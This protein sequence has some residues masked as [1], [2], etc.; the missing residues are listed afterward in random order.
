MREAICIHIG[1]GGVQIGNACWE[2]FCLEHG[3][4]PDGQMP[5]DKTIGGGDD[6]FNTFFSETGAGKHVPR[7]VMVDLEPTVVDEVR[8]GTYRQLFHPEQLISGK[9]DAAN[10]FARGH[11]TIGKEIVDLVLD[12]IRKLA[13]NCT[14]LQ[15]FCVY[16]ACGG[17]TGSG[18]GCLMLERLS[19]DYGKKSKISFTVWCC[20]QVATAVV[21]PYNT[22]LCVHS[23]LEHTDV[24]I[25][26][27]NEALYDICRRNL[28]IERPT[29]TN[30]NRLIAQIISSLT[31]SLRFDG[32]LNV[33]ITE[34]QTNLVPYPRIHFMLTSY[35]PVISAEKAYH[36]Q[37]S[38]AEITM[39]V[40]EP[41]SMMVKCDPRH[42]KYMAC[43]MMY[44]GD[45]VPKDVN[46]AVATIK[47]KRTI[48]F[49]DWCPTGF[50]CGINY[51]PPT[52]VPGGDLAKVMRACC[53]ISNSTAIAEVFSRIDH[54]FDLMYSKRA[55]VHHYVGEGMEEGEFSEA[56]ED[57][58]A[59]EKDYEEVGIETA[60]GEVLALVADFVGVRRRGLD[61]DHGVSYAGTALG[62]TVLAKQIGFLAGLEGLSAEADT[63]DQEREGKDDALYC[64]QIGNACWELFCLEHGIQPDGQMPSDKT[65]GGGDDAFNTF[66]S[67]TGAGKHVPR[68]VMVDL[69]PTVVDEVRT[70][71][72]RQLFHPE[73]LISGKEDAANNF[74][75][76]HYTIGKEIVDLVLDRIRKLADN[77]TGLQG[78][79]VYNACGG[80]TGSGLGCLMLERLSV[81]YGKKSK[82]SFT[83]WCCPQ[84]AT[85]V[86]E[87]YNTVLCVHSLL[88][89]TDVTIMYDNE[90]LYDICRRNLDIER[91]TYTN[92][93]RLIAQII[94][95]LTASLRFDGALNVDITEF[96]TNLVP[97]PRIHFM[98]T[99][100]AP[101]ISAEKAY[102]EQLSVAEITM[103]VFEPASMMVK[104][105]P[106]HGKYMACCMMYRGDVVPKDVNAAVATIKTKRT[107]QFVDW[108]PTGFKCG[109]N[110]QPPTVVPGGDLAKVMRACCMISNSTAIAEVFSR[111]D[112]KFDLMYSKRAF[113]HHYV[114]E[115][116]EEGEFSE[117][118][119]DLA[120]LEKDYEEV[121]I[122]TAEGEGEEEGYGAICIH[123][124]QGGVQIGN[125]CWELFCLEHGIQPD[126]QMPSDKTIGG[127]DDAFNTFFS[128]TG[129]GKHVPRCVMVDLEPTVVDEVR[130]G[131][132]RQLFHPEQLISGKE[133]AANNF[134]RGHYTIGKEIVDLVLDRIRKLADNC[135]GLQGFCVY[136]ACGGGTGS[137]LGCLMLE[138]LSVDY[139]K[140][141]KISFT[142]WCCPQVATAVVEPYNTVLCVH[143]LLE[144]T[145][146]TIMYDNEA[147]Y[148]ICRRNLDIERPT[149][150]NL[151]RLIAQIISSLTASL[152]FD[153]AL[154]V[155]ITE[156]QTNLVPYPRIHFMLTSYAPVISAEKAY[157]EQLSV[158]EITM[159]VFEP[160][161]MMVKCDPR[162]GK[163]MACCMMYRGDVVP[164]DVNAA[165]ATIKTKRT[166][167]FVDWCPTGFKCG[168]NYQ[169]PT[170]VPGGDLAKVMRACCMISNSTAIAEV[171]SRID[172]KFDLMYS[173]RAFVHHYVGEGMEEGEFSEARED[174][175]ALEKD[176]EEVGIETA[177]GEGEEEGYGDEF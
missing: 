69:E 163:Y 123:I 118:R 89:H 94:S 46:A 4:Q 61:S 142:V 51:Q 136:N 2:L 115:G 41:A 148:D 45:V 152:R 22:V 60:E 5:S 75:R 161:S 102:H 113:V 171:F 36:E 141:S 160:A 121:G 138:R 135:T 33:D 16:N 6:A 73:Q 62:D 83:V 49:V 34:F 91:P 71:T 172:H 105:D 149:Y 100:Y 116:M 101:V 55:F 108:C 104:C 7:C 85:A 84:V 126:G 15:G 129:A 93:N 159:S 35:A 164:K 39:S 98:L 24:T 27:D 14:G 167:Q 66:F 20:P 133:D 42:G 13:D 176:Y 59:L 140:K 134:A 63:A 10:N 147:L 177:E 1:Q 8:T 87:P 97:Y 128:E 120:A 175:A 145:D 156:F 70:G 48:Q 88:E 146:V 96:Q 25:M 158:A 86:V 92:L 125:A 31:A 107:I 32:A 65:I 21:E 112:H 58:A 78:F 43:C 109:I 151:N 77:C 124:G 79:C 170:V 19:V 11:Y 12:R 174:L 67:E 82:I 23:L 3:I 74:A 173:K 143:S 56:R 106:R 166:I 130:T 81:D 155:D 38:V 95:S 47:T 168:I 9:E 40:F 114:G 119:E 90:A 110:Y 68:C 122:E 139:G 169:P 127:G 28:D 144:H 162:H 18:L 53:M 76:G 165:V 37:L 72:Y 64:V 153:G 131:T 54:K 157:H 111:I 50:K 99:S 150:T 30:L 117:A 57:L 132:Y 17:G 154:N 103:S 29:Y 52:V 137:G 80:G 44:R 26:Y